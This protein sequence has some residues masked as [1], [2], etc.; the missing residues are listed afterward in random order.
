MPNVSVFVA[1]RALHRIL[2][3][4]IDDMKG[5]MK[6]R[7]RV[8]ALAPRVRVNPQA[9]QWLTGILS[10]A[11]I[12]GLVS[13]LGASQSAPDDATV[14]H[15]VVTDIFQYAGE[16]VTVRDLWSNKYVAR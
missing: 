15:A 9:N 16:C 11:F 10:A 8:L 6:N 5:A 14:A 1:Q 3:T 4:S 2:Q 12:C 7:A 13:S